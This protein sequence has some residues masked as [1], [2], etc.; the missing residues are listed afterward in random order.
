MAAQAPASATTSARPVVRLRPGKQ[1]RVLHG[2]PWIYSNE[3][4]MDAA[5][6]ALPPGSIARIERHNGGP[7][8]TAMFHPH[9]LIAARMLSRDPQAAIDAAFLRDKIERALEVR[10]RMFP[11]PFYRLVHAEA[12]DLPGLVIDRYGDVLA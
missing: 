7:V 9:T 2:H 11:A 1:G 12:D 10:Q 6:K 3:I 8:G 4:E 5:A